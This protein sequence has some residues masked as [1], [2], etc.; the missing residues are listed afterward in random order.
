MRFSEVDLILSGNKIYHLDIC[1]DNLA[2]TILTVGDPDRVAAVTRHF[3]SIEYKH[4]HRGFILHTGTY[5]NQRLSVLATCIGTQNIDIVINELDALVNIDLETRTTKDTLRSLNL[6]R[7]GTT[8]AIQESINLNTI[9]LTE[10]SIDMTGVMLYYQYSMDQEAR[11]MIS[12]LESHLFDKFPAIP[13]STFR[14]DP[15]L[16]DF[17][18]KH[19]DCL[20]GITLTCPGF[21]A[22]QGRQL[23][24]HTNSFGFIENLSKFEYNNQRIT[25][26]EMETA[27]IYGLATILGHRCCSLNMVLANRITREF[28]SNVAQA[29]EYLIE[30]TLDAIR[31]MN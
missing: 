8:G 24:A 25:N 26:L 19:G 7:L 6:I 14:A 18:L 16:V 12:A 13:L 15:S 23:R 27:A 17:F 30:F 2:D 31:H 9:I 11:Q 22:A 3:Q 4:H 29:E 21:Y 20:K 28:H 10:H 1:A 5:N